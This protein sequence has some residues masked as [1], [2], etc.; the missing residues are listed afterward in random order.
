[1]S[2]HIC[3][4]CGKKMMQQ[5]IGLKHCKVASADLKMSDISEGLPI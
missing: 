1:M 5:F 3:S 2:E 4:E